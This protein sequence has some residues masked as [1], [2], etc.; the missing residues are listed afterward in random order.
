LASLRGAG[1][2]ASFAELK[3][4]RREVDDIHSILINSGMRAVPQLCD[5]EASKSAFMSLTDSRVNVLHVATHG[6][7]KD[8]KQSTDA[9][10]MQ[11]SMLVFAGANL[12]DNSFVTAADIASMNLRQCD[13][14]VLSACETGLGKLGGDGVFGL[15]RGFKNAGVHTL[16]MSLK[17]VYDAST[18]DL[19]ISFY[20]HLMSGA[21]KREALVKAQQD[22]RSKGYN[23]PKYWAVFIL[24]D[25]Y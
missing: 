10:S 23:D 20:R 8:V 12:D 19:M 7:Y 9:E 22:I 1:E 11:N 21:T 2:I 6:M 18:A 13:L 15:Q 25:A 16:L 5:T 24:L 3:N 4:T 14:A 17:K